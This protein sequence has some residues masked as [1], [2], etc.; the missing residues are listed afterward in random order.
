MAYRTKTYVAGD[1]DEDQNLISQLEKWNDDR[2]LSLHFLPAH[3]LC[4]AR[5]TSLN[6]SIKRSLRTRLEASKTF[7]LIVGAS[8]N[9]VT[10]GSCKH[11]GNY[12]GYWH[13]CNRGYSADMRSYINYEC[14]YAKNNGLK[15]VVLY[16]YATVH[17]DKCPE[18][19][20]YL[21]THVPAYYK[22]VDG[23]Y[24]WDYQAIKDAI[25]S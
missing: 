23:N 25:N 4:C 7:V 10:A 8:T 21:G 14:E 18:A 13:S 19:V 17:R 5:D 24:Y 9:S 15:I 20:R 22:S 6:C 1:W 16:N 3:D 11:C 2:R 12:S